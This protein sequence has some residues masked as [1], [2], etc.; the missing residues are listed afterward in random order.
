LKL[1]I[2]TKTLRDYRTRRIYL[3]FTLLK[4]NSRVVAKQ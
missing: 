1:E 3:Y 4:Y 2:K